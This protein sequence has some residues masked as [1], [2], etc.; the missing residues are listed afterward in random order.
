MEV[1]ISIEW[2]QADVIV[3]LVDRVAAG[4]VHAL[5]PVHGRTDTWHERKDPIVP[6]D[7]VRAWI[8]VEAANLAETERTARIV[9]AALDDLTES[10]DVKV[11]EWT[12][13]IAD[14]AAE[15]KA[16]VKP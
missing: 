11:Q 1:M 13:F 14:R 15:R 9:M 7:L 12:A 2:R 5:H 10:A 4:I 6:G 3:S 8:R 16:R